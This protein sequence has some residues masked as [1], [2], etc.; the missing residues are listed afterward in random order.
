VSPFIQAGPGGHAGGYLLQ[1]G[2]YH[3]TL[4]AIQ[5]RGQPQCENRAQV[6]EPGKLQAYVAEFD[7]L[8]VRLTVDGKKVVEYREQRPLIGD[9]HSQVGFYLYEGDVKIQNVRVFTSPAVPE[10]GKGYE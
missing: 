8:N 6:I 10:D 9:G 5:R 2:G 1:F 4:S 7:G 3:N